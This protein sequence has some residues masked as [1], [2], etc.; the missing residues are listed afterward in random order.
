MPR[1]VEIKAR[2][3][4]LATLHEQIFTLAGRPPEIIDQEDVF[5]VVP[6]G[7]LKL[8]ILTPG[9]G[10]LIY[11]QRPDSTGPETSHYQIAHSDDPHGLLAV[12]AAAY[13]TGPTV[14]KRRWLYLIGRT[15]VH[16]DRVEGLGDFLELEVVLADGEDEASGRAE[17]E[18][19]LA[20]LDISPAQLIA[21]AYA[22]L[23]SSRRP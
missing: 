15:R 16:L 18:Q 7:R 23:L 6:N 4:D 10:Q 12:L 22:D 2:V 20:L 11:Y 9:K 13:G 19:L 21:T 17:A 8:R 14:R 1:N 5:F 3:N